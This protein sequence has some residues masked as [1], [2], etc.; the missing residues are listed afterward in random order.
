M[1]I[2]REKVGKHT[3]T[4]ICFRGLRIWICLGVWLRPFFRRYYD[5]GLI[6][7]GCLQI[8]W[9]PSVLRRMRG[10]VSLDMERR[11]RYAQRRFGKWS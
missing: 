3:Q 11:I 7:I 10:E 5:W 8:E 9:F 2:I 6:E 4:G 1:K